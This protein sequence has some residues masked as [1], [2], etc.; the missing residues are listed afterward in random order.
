MLDSAARAAALAAAPLMNPRRPTGLLSASGILGLY[1][2]RF[3]MRR[4][5]CVQDR[6]FDSLPEADFRLWPARAGPFLVQRAIIAKDDVPPRVT[7]LA[8]AP[9]RK[10]DVR[11]APRVALG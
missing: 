2:R 9:D 8:R 1:T 10:T 7:K 4:V 6:S 5:F 3:I 11:S